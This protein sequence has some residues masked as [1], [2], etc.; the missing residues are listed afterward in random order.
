MNGWTHGVAMEWRRAATDT[1]PAPAQRSAAQHMTGLS[2]GLVRATH[3]RARQCQR[4][5][6]QARAGIVRKRTQLPEARTSQE[7]SWSFKNSAACPIARIRYAA[8]VWPHLKRSCGP[9]RRSKNDPD[10]H[11]FFLVPSSTSRP[12]SSPPTPNTRASHTPLRIPF[13]YL[14]RQPCNADLQVTA[15][16]ALPLTAALPT[17]TRRLVA[18]FSTRSGPTQARSRTFWTA[19]A[20]PL[21]RESKLCTSR[22]RCTR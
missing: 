8:P 18:A 10:V 14:D 21:S 19:S 7:I 22:W 15:S 4:G 1:A 17:Q 2:T 11:L 12:V 13:A 16:A 3:G 6:G 20:S 5:A 9:E